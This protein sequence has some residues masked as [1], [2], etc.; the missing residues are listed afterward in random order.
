[1]VD[2]N[3]RLVEV[4]SILEKLDT[5]YK[6]KIPN[7]KCYNTVVKAMYMQ[8]SFSKWWNLVDCLSLTKVDNAN[9]DIDKFYYYYEY[10]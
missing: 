6:N 1:M 7:E 5:N 3:K 10:I 2:V 8:A 4:E 9:G